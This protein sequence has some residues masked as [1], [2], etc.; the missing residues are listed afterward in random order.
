MKQP[1]DL[2]QFQH[3]YLMG[4]KGVAMTSL[5]QILLDFGKSVA[6]CDV[7][8][9]FVT[10]PILDH[11]SISI[12]SG[13]LHSLPEKT[14]CVIYTSAHGGPA[15]PIVL[16][17]QQ[18]NIPAISEAEALAYFFNQK[19]GI[20]VCGVGGK[21]TVSAMIAWILTQAELIPSFSVGVGKIL[22]LN[23]TGNWQTESKQFVAEADEYVIDPQFQQHDQLMVPRFSFLQPKVTVCTNVAFDHP[24]VY[25]SIQHT[26]EIFASFFTQIKGGGTIIFNQDSEAIEEILHHCQEYFKQNKIKQLSFGTDSQATAQLVSHQVLKK[27]NIGEILFEGKRG[28]LILRLPGQFN[29]LNGLAAALAANQVG[30]DFAQ[31]L[32]SLTSFQGTQRRFEHKGIKNGVDYYDD[33]AHHPSELKNTIEALA[34]WHP[35]QRKV[36]VFQPHTYSRTRELFKEFVEALATA[37]EVLLLDIFPSAR[38]QYDSTISAD[39]LVQ[40]V[41]KDHPEV[42]IANLKTINSL[43]DYCQHQ[44]EAGD[45][46]I[47]MGAGDIYQVH[48]ML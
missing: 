9:K 40:A 7:S 13:F 41:K 46:L 30:V 1:L 6:G 48:E 38:E 27:Q 33:Y 8:E 2:S 43:V 15:N 4:I 37:Q 18:R 26:Q 14:E 17:A 34:S 11:L 36:V 3:F 21:T 45:V 42:K 29:L 16:Q 20:G 32:A 5:T 28:Q 10:Q 44:L 19:E 12:S 25:H 23:Q 39:L 35:D 47:T 24:D 31:A 22:G